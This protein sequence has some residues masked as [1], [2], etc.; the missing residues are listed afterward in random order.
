MRLTHEEILMS[1]SPL[2]RVS[3]IGTAL[4]VGALGFAACSSSDSG[5]AGS[6]AGST[7]SAPIAGI[8]SLDVLYEGTETSPPSE[9]PAPAA[10]K[11]VWFISC[12]QQVSGCAAVG[13]AT[14]EAVSA[15]GWDFKLADGNLGIG[16][17][18]NAAVRTALAAK[19]DALIVHGFSC[20]DA[21]QSLDE[22][23]QQG[24]LVIGLENT[25]C[26]DEGGPKLFTADMMYTETVKSNTDY[27]YQFGQRAAQYVI[28]VSNG[29]AKVINNPGTDGLGEIVDK[30]FTEELAKCP[31]CEIVDTVPAADQDVTPNGPWI[32]AFRSSLVRNPDA[33]STFLP[34]DFLMASVGGAQAI[35]ESN[36]KLVSF[37]GLGTLD[38]Q[39]QI[40]QGLITAVPAARSVGWMGWAAVD[41]LNRAF[42]NQPAVPEGNGFVLVDQEHGLPPAGEDYQT[43]VDYKSAYLKAWGISQ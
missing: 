12:G 29:R 30:G 14:K 33:T 3:I 18:Y 27:W 26:S 13:E 28:N 19:P 40:R 36:L 8:P 1:R 42:Q 20:A 25:D 43:S 6:S 7:V 23:R 37:G 17:G 11:S 35:R 38:S 31:D 15:I 10:D 5:S 34:W 24:V 2:R 16:G 22:A 32:Q 21:Q 39:D 4:A 9:A 41:N